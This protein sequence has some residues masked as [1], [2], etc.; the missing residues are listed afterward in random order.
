MNPYYNSALPQNPP[1]PFSQQQQAAQMY[2][3][4]AYSSHYM[5]AIMQS[6]AG[7]FQQQPGGFGGA[8]QYPN[9]PGPSTRPIITRPPP[10]PAGNWYQPGNRRCTY[11]GC[12]F[13]GSHSSVETHMMDRHL[14]YPPG[15]EKRKKQQDWDADPSLKGK[16]VPIQGTNITL[17][18]PEQLVKWIEERKKRFPTKCKVE[19]KK[20][21]MD[22][23]IARGQLTEED[24]GVR[25]GKRRRTNELSGRERNHDSSRGRAGARGARGRQA[26]PNRGRGWGGFVV[27][28]TPTPLP[29]KPETTALQPRTIALS[30][31][32]S[33]SDDDSDSDEPPEVVSS[34]KDVTP[35]APEPVTEE[36]VHNEGLSPEDIASQR[37][38]ERKPLLPPQPRQPP[39]NPFANRPSLLR[40][41]ILPE[42]R[43]TV[44]NLSQAIRFLVDNN[45]LLD[46]ELK[47]GEASE[48]PIQVLKSVE[49]DSR[50]SVAG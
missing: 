1:W 34:K 22:E 14:I 48:T 6:Q 26:G 36:P 17:D 24:M 28:N 44:S 5:Q 38:T 19:D 42:I 37:A 29:D 12:T 49:N 11:K 23:A 16:P 18:D 3:N 50:Y 13:T 2:T 39:R 9:M 33:D 41:L 31:E 45:F 20:R 8:Q 32:S 10:P 30:I 40:S 46:V 43:I 27:A 4:P 21:K 25:P 35:L 15:W 47:P 7:Y